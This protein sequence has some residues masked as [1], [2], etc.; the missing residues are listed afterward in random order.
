[1][2]L[3]KLN[4]CHSSIDNQNNHY[5]NINNA[6][7]VAISE[8]MSGNSDGNDDSSGEDGCDVSILQ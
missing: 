2:L 7:A 4:Y 1:M 3:L 8:K 6:A 5:Y